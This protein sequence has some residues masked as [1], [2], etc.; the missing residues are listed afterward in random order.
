MNTVSKIAYG[1]KL[2]GMPPSE[3]LQSTDGVDWPQINV[4]VGRYRPPDASAS[5]T[6][7]AVSF[8]LGERAYVHLDRVRAEAKFAVRGRL[9]DDELVHPYLGYAAAVF[10]R[11]LGREPFHGG[12]FATKTGAWAVLGPRDAGKSTFLAHLARDG[13][14][15]IT[16][17]LLVVDRGKVYVGPRCIDLR[18]SAAEALD[19]PGKAPGARLGRRWRVILP[20]EEPETPLRGLIFLEWGARTKVSRIPARDRLACLAAHRSILRPPVDPELFLELAQV[21]AWRLTRPRSWSAVPSALAGLRD[22]LE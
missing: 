15:V 8:P 9:G 3:A 12:G 6:P 14:G 22:L 17:D 13:F 5:P 21:P 2:A 19:L 18:R 7:D 10:A 11:W 4:V 20:G 1:L 16:D